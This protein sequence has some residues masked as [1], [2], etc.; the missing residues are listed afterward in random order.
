[1]NKAELI[2][3]VAEKAGLTKKD[4]EKAVVAIFDSIQQAMVAVSYTHLA[5]LKRSRQRQRRASVSRRARRS[6]LR[7]ARP[8]CSPAGTAGL[9][10]A[11]SR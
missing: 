4:A 2:A 6:G 5:A 8:A 11:A 9:R 1:M 7:A 3:S 10:P